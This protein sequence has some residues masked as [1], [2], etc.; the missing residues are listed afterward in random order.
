VNK[1]IPCEII[2]F[3]K[4]VKDKLKCEAEGKSE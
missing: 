2:D 4:K 3:V 1:V